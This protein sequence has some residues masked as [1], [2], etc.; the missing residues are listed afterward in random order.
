[1]GRPDY[2]ILDTADYVERLVAVLPYTQ[3]S[4]VAVEQMLEACIG[5]LQLQRRG[6]SGH[7][8]LA[9]WQAYA[10]PLVDLARTT[11]IDTNFT[12]VMPLIRQLLEHLDERCQ[13]F[14]LYEN[15]LLPYFYNGRVN[16]GAI[17]LLG[18]QAWVRQKPPTT[19]VF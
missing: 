13:E 3:R 7:E 16:N 17:S 11:A 19:S 5:I 9:I 2:V 4:D 14:K 10:T 15:N 18:M 1:M 6:A 12:Q 8:I